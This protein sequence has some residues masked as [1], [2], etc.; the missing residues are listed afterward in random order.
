MK[1]AP[2]IL[3]SLGFKRKQSRHYTR[4]MSDLDSSG[5]IPTNPLDPDQVVNTIPENYVEEEIISPAGKANLA[6]KWTPQ[7]ERLWG[8]VSCLLPFTIYS[9]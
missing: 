8:R 5:L 7:E 9:C 4:T 6:K 3:R 2:S 1:L